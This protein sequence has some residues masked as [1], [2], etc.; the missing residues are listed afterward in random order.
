MKN[1]TFKHKKTGELITYKDGCIYT[2]RTVIEAEP[3]LEFW[4]E[5]VEKEWEILSFKNTYAGF[6]CELKPDGFYHYPIA[7][8]ELKWT[9]KQ[10]LDHPETLIQSIKRLSDGEVFTLGDRLSK[11]TFIRTIT[12][13]KNQ[14][15]LG[16]NLNLEISLSLV[17]KMNPLFKTF[18]G[19]DVFEGDTTYIVGTSTGIF[20]EE[21]TRI[22]EKV[23]E[24]GTGQLHESSCIQGGKIYWLKFSSKEKAEEYILMNK[25]CLSLQE[26]MN[27][28]NASLKELVKSRL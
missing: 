7:E 27:N 14:C 26:A 24:V 6:P 12:M 9:E 17:K 11:D 22:E 19:V 8:S 5:V 23:S 21:K 15:W 25:P 28:N 4:E 3:N 16:V 1:K 13:L 18:D 20:T 2:N 10:F